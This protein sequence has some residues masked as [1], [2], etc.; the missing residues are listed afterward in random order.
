VG[1]LDAFF[2]MAQWMEETHLQP[3]NSLSLPQA[4]SAEGQ[5]EAYEGQAPALPA[6][7]SQ[8]PVKV[9]DEL[10]VIGLAA[11]AA[12]T[13]ARIERPKESGIRSQRP[14]LRGGTHEL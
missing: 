2:S 8:T 14:E 7:A 1:T 10:L 11:L 13:V 4:I 3:S 6:G 9:G 12:V 5:T